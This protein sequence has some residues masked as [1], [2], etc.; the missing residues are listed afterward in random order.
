MAN[1]TGETDI[2]ADIFRAYTEKITIVDIKNALSRK[3]KP[4][5]VARFGNIHLIYKSLRKAD[6]VAGA[7]SS[8]CSTVVPPL[9]LRYWSRTV[10]RR[11]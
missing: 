8:G 9:A 3:F 7:M 5:Q 1:E 2:E 11:V 10:A 4:E 6:L